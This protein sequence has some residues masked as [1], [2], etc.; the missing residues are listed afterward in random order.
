MKTTFSD[1]HGDVSMTMMM[2]TISF[3][4]DDVLMMMMKTTFSRRLG[5]AS[6]RLRTCSMNAIGGGHLIDAYPFCD[7]LKKLMM[8]GSWSRENCCYFCVAFRL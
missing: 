3:R 5:D 6:M 7:D 1:R 8:N 4:H 2:W